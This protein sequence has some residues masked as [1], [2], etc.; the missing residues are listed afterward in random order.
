[1]SASVAVHVGRFRRVPRALLERAVRRTLVAEGADGGELS[2]ALLGDDAIRA[3]NRDHLGHDR[4]TDVLAFALHGRGEPVL[5]DVYLGVPQA[6]RQAAEAD[7][8]EAE[9]LVRLAVHGTLHV[10]GWDHP[11]A[12]PAR[13]RSP[14]WTRQEELVAEVLRSR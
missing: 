5:G 9:E 12:G 1:M 7:V 8:T 11:A 13:L 10:L 6:R 4:V 3:L 2:V 14:M